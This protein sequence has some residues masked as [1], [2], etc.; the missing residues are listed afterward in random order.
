MPTN[1]K[2]NRTAGHAWERTSASILRETKFF[3]HVVTSRSESKARDDKKIDLMNKDEVDNGRLIYSIQCKNTTTSLP[4][5]K[6]LAEMPDD[7]YMNVLFHNQTKKRGDRFMSI[8]Q[9]AALKLEDFIKLITQIEELKH[10]VNTYFD[11]HTI[12]EQIEIN[13]KL[14]TLGL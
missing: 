8:G 2:R 10:I 9:Y 3:P 13:D 7:G 4:Y 5:P 11:N 1:G 14:K 12:E 6:L